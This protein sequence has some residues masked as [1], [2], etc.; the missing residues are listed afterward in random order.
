MKLGILGAGKIAGVM[1][2]TIR[3]LN[4]VGH[5]EVELYA[6]AARDLVR[7]QAF[8]QA[9]GVQKSFGS[10]EEML[11]DPAL[12]LV[13]IATP[14][15]H[16]YR[17]IKLCA[18]HG[19][20]ILCEKA[21]TVSARQAQDAIRYARARGVLV[22]EAIWTRYQPMRGMINDV[23]ASGAIGVPKLLTANLGYSVAG[24]QRIA[25]P[26]LAGGALLDVGIYTLNFA[27]MIFGHCSTLHGLC[28]KNEKGVDMTD[29]IVLSWDD[30]RTANLTA[31]ANALSDRAG[32]VYGTEGYLVVEN[33]NNPQAMQ[34][35][36]AK[37]E[38]VQRVEC[39]AQLTGYE[40]EVLETADCIRKG[41]LECPSMPHRET[42]RMMELMDHLRAQMGI[43]YPCEALDADFD[44]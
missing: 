7:A 3:K 39:P 33:I 38:L 18:D 27:E 44:Q 15:S 29:S 17:Q 36:N 28:T 32:V 14:H 30:G 8:A 12:D 6:V 22:T 5:S 16:H 13:Y 9:N 37:R 21:F 2:D 41:L 31:A 26:E 10:Y 25:E 24:K 40:Y 4:A 42:V 19:K 35:Y 1:A 11:C 34:V 43:V 23:L 20:H